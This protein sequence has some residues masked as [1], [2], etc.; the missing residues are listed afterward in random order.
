MKNK[1]R[2]QNLR[3]R[4]N[5]SDKEILVKS[6]E[7][8]K[9]LFSLPEYKESHVVMFYV[10][11]G[12][13]VFTH[14][15]IKDALKDKIVVVPKVV[16][17]EMIAVKINNFDELSP[18]AFGILEPKNSA[19]FPKKKIEAVMI[20]GIA[21]SLDKHRIGYG[22]GFYDK[23]LKGVKSVKIALAYDFKILEQVPHEK[24][25]IPMDIVVTEEKII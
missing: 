7:I 18:G 23:F 13:E 17:D 15:M 1:I 12:K 14:D 10:S 20:P 3:K 6:R 24:H 16:K 21:F 8:E 9:R 4:D 22:K 25:D 5:L 11:F 19:G 2:K